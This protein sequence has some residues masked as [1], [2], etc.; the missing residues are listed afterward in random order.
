MGLAVPS[1]PSWLDLVAL[2]SGL[3]FGLSNL[4]FRAARRVPVALKITVMFRGGA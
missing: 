1:P 4:A 2:L 3:L